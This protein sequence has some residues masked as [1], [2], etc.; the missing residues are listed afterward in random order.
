VET[1]VNLTKVHFQ[2]TNVVF[3]KNFYNY[4]TV[5]IKIIVLHFIVIN[6]LTNFVTP[7]KNVFS[8]VFDFF[9]CDNYV[10]Y[11]LMRIQ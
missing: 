7:L 5:T 2:T 10:C 4:F 11:T 6:C 9:M 8:N 3:I 1:I